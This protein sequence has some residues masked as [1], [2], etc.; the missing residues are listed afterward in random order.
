MTDWADERAERII[1]ET[2]GRYKSDVVAITAQHLRQVAADIRAVLS[3]PMMMVAP[4]GRTEPLPDFDFAGYLCECRECG[5]QY[6]A[7]VDRGYC[8][9][10]LPLP[11]ASPVVP[12]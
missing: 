11:K 9:A 1:E 10:H 6:I 2:W 5:C 4:D 3:A 8:P 7:K 12:A